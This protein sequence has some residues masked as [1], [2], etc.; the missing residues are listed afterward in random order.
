MKLDILIKNGLSPISK[1]MIILIVIL[2]LSAIAS[3]T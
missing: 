2:A 1:V 3:W